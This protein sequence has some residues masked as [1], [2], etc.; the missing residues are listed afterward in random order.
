M[1]DRNNGS[2]NVVRGGFQDNDGF[3]CIL[4]V[5]GG[6]GQVRKAGAKDKRDQLTAFLN[7]DRSTVSSM[8]KS[9]HL[10][11]FLWSSTLR[12]NVFL[13]VA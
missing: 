1:M 7:V 5:E 8:S 4:T 6:G 3:E 13:S 11:V 2:L 9:I 12:F 10:S